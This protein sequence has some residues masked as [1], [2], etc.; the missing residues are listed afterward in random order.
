MADDGNMLVFSARQIED[1]IDR[2]ARG[3]FV[4]YVC[5]NNPQAYIDL[6]EEAA[7]AKGFQP[8][9]NRDLRRVHVGAT[10]RVTFFRADGPIEID[11]R[12]MF[13]RCTVVADHAIEVAPF[14]KWITTY[15]DLPGVRY[16]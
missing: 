8:K 15:A 5:P 12:F 1:A 10:G 13:A 6:A 7:V 9:V 3:D 16:A 2:A 11:R 4:A 14:A